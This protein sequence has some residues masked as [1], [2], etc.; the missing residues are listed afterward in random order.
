[1]MIKQSQKKKCKLLHFLKKFIHQL[2]K[3]KKWKK[4]Y[5]HHNFQTK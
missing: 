5:E 3:E 2:K 4:E 1:M